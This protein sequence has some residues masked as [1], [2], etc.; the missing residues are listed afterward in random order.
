MKKP[1][2]FIGGFYRGQKEF[3]KRQA[4]CNINSAIMLT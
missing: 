4:N 3:D 2:Q 1:A